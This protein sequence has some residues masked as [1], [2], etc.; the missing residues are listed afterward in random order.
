MFCIRCGAEIQAGDKFCDKCGAPQK[1]DVSAGAPRGNDMNTNDPVRKKNRMFP[2]FLLA[3]LLLVVIGVLVFL[4]FASGGKGKEYDEQL[5]LAERYL[6]ELDYDKAIAAYKAAIEIDPAKPEAYLG[7][8]EAYVAQGK[9]QK[10][11]DVLEDGYEK[12]GDERLADKIAEIEALMK[13]ELQPAEE[14]PTPTEAEQA[15][16]TPTEEPE[17]VWREISLDEIPERAQLDKMFYYSIWH[18]RADYDSSDPFAGDKAD[19]KYCSVID[20]IMGPI[21]GVPYELY[22]I[23][24]PEESW[25]WEYRE[26]YGRYE[27]LME[28]KTINGG[29]YWSIYKRVCIKQ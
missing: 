25:D 29:K 21:P 20:W 17:R 16:A 10:A 1:S 3:G 6:D 5:K 27:T 23:E 4:I 18:D 14:I 12:T 24:Q 26:E 11:I 7:L 15:Q 28:L 19:R 9:Y 8:A 22:P 2:I 13:A